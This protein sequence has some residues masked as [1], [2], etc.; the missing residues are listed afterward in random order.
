MP[1]VNSWEAELAKD[2]KDQEQMIA[3]SHRDYRMERTG[4]Y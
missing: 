3:W 1:N 4:G 2:A